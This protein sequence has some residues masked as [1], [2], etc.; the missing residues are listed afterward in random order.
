VVRGRDGTWFMF[1][2]GVGPA[3]R[4]PR[5]RIGLATSADLHH[6]STHPGS[7]VLESDSRWYEHFRMRC[8]PTRHGVIRGYWLTPTVTAGTCS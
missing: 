2:T 5:Q 1:Y 4:A 7:P 3:D 8:S 6:W